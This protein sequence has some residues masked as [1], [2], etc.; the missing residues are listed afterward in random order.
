MYKMY[1]DFNLDDFSFGLMLTELYS[2]PRM[3]KKF[4]PTKHQQ[5]DSCDQD[6]IFK[7]I[8]YVGGFA[9]S[10]YIQKFIGIYFNY[11]YTNKIQIKNLI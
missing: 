7:N 3:F 8:I 1:L 9:H 11:Q 2:I 5:A 6:N 10:N 4:D